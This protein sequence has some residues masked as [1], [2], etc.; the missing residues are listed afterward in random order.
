MVR[1]RGASKSARNGIGMANLLRSPL[2][3]QIRAVP[4]IPQRVTLS[5][6][7]Y[8]LVVSSLG[9]RSPAVQ[10]GLIQPPGSPSS[11]RDSIGLRSDK[12]AKRSR[13]ARRIQ[14]LLRIVNSDAIV[15]VRI[16]LSQPV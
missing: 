1:R 5:E 10:G 6:T 13:R 9:G 14:S 16:R 2:L 3:N 8:K 11:H 7:W 15:R 12:A 4:G